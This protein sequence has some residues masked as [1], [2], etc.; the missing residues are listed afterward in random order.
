MYIINK[1]VDRFKIFRVINPRE[2]VGD[3]NYQT[4]QIQYRRVS[5]PQIV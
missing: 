1:A 4:G 5:A 3:G 2:E